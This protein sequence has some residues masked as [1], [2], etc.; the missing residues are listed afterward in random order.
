MT[1]TQSA[2]AQ[3]V[4]ILWVNPIN[5]PAYDQPIA[6][7]IKSMKRP[8]TKVD[9]V[10]LVLPE[11]IRLTDLED[12]SSEAVVWDPIT[13]LAHYAGK[14]GYHGYAIGCF[15]DTALEEAREVSGRTVVRAPCEASLKIVDPLCDKFSVIIGRN[16]WEKQM[17]DRIKFYGMEHKLASFRSFGLHVDEFQ[18]DKQYTEQAIRKAVKFAI[19]E[20]GAQAIILGCTIEF[21]FFES[22]QREFNC[23]VV[24]VVYACYLEVEASAT[25]NARF[26]WSPSHTGNLAPTDDHRLS[27]NGVFEREVPIGNTVRILG[28]V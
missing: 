27:L 1:S 14:N 19:E 15:Y 2:K 18:R 7:L 3:P 10:S 12:R 6:D 23:P 20:D 25:M 5:D 11:P 9:V 17:R 24:D 21:G 8:E 16:K 28:E 22:L 4:K 26:G 13:Q